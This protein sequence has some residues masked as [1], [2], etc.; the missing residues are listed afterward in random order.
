MLEV[1]LRTAND[2]KGITADET[3]VLLAAKRANIALL[4]IYYIILYY[5]ILMF[6]P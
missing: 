5:I 1:E 3:A 6:P 4:G 2:L